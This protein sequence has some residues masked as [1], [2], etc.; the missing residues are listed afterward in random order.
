M[1]RTR[2]RRRCRARKKAWRLGRVRRARIAKC[3]QRTCSSDSGRV[4]P[5]AGRPCREEEPAAGGEKPR[6]L[7]EEFLRLPGS[8]AGDE[9]AADHEVEGP[10]RKI[11][12][13]DPPGVALEEPDPGVRGPGLGHGDLGELDPRHPAGQGVEPGRE[14]ALAAPQIQRR[15]EA[16][17]RSVPPQELQ[18][19]P[20][21]LRVGGPDLPGI[22][23]GPVELLEVPSHDHP[24]IPARLPISC[25]SDRRRRSASPTEPRIRLLQRARCRASTRK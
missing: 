23:L 11:Q 25:R 3:R 9:I 13:P 15:G 16:G 10:R 7:P 24:V 6:N 8:E 19:D 18:V 5:A 12:I 21:A 14:G 2:S 1:V 17:R 4:V 22:L 20:V